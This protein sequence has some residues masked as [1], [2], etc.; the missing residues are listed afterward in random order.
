MYKVHSLVKADTLSYGAVVN[1]ATLASCL[2]SLLARDKYSVYE[3]IQKQLKDPIEVQKVSKLFSL[4]CDLYVAELALKLIRFSFAGYFQQI[5]GVT[6]DTKMGLS[7][8][9]L[10]A[11]VIEEQ[12]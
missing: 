6:I 11:S 4:T 10:F 12:K 5:N 8:A 1:D 9:N 2:S 7:Y 3:L